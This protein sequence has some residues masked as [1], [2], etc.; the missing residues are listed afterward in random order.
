MGRTFNC[1]DEVKR[2]CLSYMNDQLR[3]YFDIS[4]LKGDKL[5]ESI[6]KVDYYKTY[7]FAVDII[8]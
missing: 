8:A 1:S 3:K 7:L 2:L 4:K 5:F 6:L